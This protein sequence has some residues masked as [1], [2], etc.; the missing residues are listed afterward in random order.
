MRRADSTSGESRRFPG[1][2]V[3]AGALAVA[4][5]ALVPFLSGESGPLGLTSTVD[6]PSVGADGRASGQL[7]LGPGVLDAAG[8]PLLLLQQLP[9]FDQVPL[10][11]LGAPVV[12]ALGIPE[13]ALQAYR[14]AEQE[15][16]RLAPGCHISWSLLAAIGRVESNH[17]RGGRVDANGTTLTPILGPILD[18][19]GFAAVPDTDGGRYDGNTTWDRAV[20]PMQFIPASWVKYASDG[21]GDGVADPNNV[22]DAAL[23]AGK[24][25]C[26][27]GGDL[28][29]PQQRA[30]AVFRYNHSD[31]YVRTVLLWA[32][33]YERGASSIP[34]GQ[35]PAGPVAGSAGLPGPAVEPP[36][37]PVA[38]A[39]PA[40]PV[41]A[42]P[43]PASPGA[44]PAKTSAPSTTRSSS[45]T[46]SSSSGTTAP[47]TCPTTTPPSSTSD[48]TTTPPA[49]TTT[50]PPPSTTTSTTTTTTSAT[51]TTPSC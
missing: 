43:A 5:L 36:P 3:K 10:T 49:T 51:T 16:A 14:R 46:T 39:P 22:Y 11:P 9:S 24:Y 45:P 34:D 20:G 18:G 37:A 21:N 31:D 4:S 2:R 32:D 30:Q 12:G 13:S 17:A 23:S 41:T 50:T 38:A 8:S 19:A 29:D 48:T 33:A 6:T 25:L 1:R 26:A 40:P 7:R 35:L 47:P 42:T 28:R 15:L 27:G 44:P